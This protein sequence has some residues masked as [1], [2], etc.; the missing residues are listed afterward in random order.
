MKIFKHPWLALFLVFCLPAQALAAVLAECEQH[1][2]IEATYNQPG[3]RET[4]QPEPATAPAPDCHGSSNKSISTDSDKSAAEAL[5]A[6]TASSADATSCFHCSGA[7]Q[8]LKPLSLIS[9][10]QQAP[11]FDN[12][13]FSRFNQA[14]EAGIRSNPARPPCPL[15]RS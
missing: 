10:T 13:A 6:H 5:S 2:V 11:A 14:P 7:C 1:D 12:A 8:N 9:K 4:S 3:T 15:I